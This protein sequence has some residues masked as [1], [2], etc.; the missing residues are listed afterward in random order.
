VSKLGL[1]SDPALARELVGR[2]IDAGLRKGRRRGV[3]AAKEV[4]EQQHDVRNVRGTIVVGV[5]GIVAAEVREPPEKDEEHEYRDGD[6]CVSVAAGIAA[7]KPWLVPTALP[8][9][10]VDVHVRQ[11]PRTRLPTTSGWESF[12]KPMPW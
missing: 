11:F 7:Q 1:I 6:V 9:E 5:S 8:L 12:L 10:R 3:T 4:V 2:W